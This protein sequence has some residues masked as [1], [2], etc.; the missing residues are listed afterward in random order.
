MNHTIRLNTDE[1]DFLNK[2]NIVYI[3]RYK[4]SYVIEIIDNIYYVYYF[5]VFNENKVRKIWDYACNEL[6]I[7]ND[8]I[9]LFNQIDTKEYIYN[10]EEREY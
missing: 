9:D 2:Y 4:K 3:T 6:I 7:N 5:K 10:V 8:R 1:I